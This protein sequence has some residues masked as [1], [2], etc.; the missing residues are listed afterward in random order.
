MKYY[1][2]YKGDE[3]LTVGTKK[4]LAKYLNVSENTIRFYASPTYQRRNKKGNGY[5][6]VKVEDDEEKEVI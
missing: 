3:L 4:E 2:L 5:L 6:V 1:A